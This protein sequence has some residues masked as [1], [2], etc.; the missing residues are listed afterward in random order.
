MKFPSQ[1]VRLI[2][3]HAD[4]PSFVSAELRKLI[5]WLTTAPGQATDLL[6][7]QAK[8]LWDKGIGI[9]LSIN[10]F[11]EYV[12]SLPPVPVHYLVDDQLL[13]IVCLADPRPGLVWGAA[14]AHI[15]YD[16]QNNS[17][18]ECDRRHRVGK[19]PFWFRAHNGERNSGEKSS[20][21][22]TEC[23]GSL[24]AGTVEV[25]LAIKIQRGWFHGMHLPGSVD[26]RNSSYYAYI[27]D[28]HLGV[29]WGGEYGHGPYSTDRT[30]VFSRD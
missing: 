2:A 6:L 3:L 17:F 4:N 23:V 14:A 1:I 7:T 9:K 11:D 16:M 5:D 22:L 15:K 25:G 26:R 10:S 18:M 30:V 21:V 29:R 27:D 20:D 19:Q 12:A 8:V 24:L 28:A 13:E